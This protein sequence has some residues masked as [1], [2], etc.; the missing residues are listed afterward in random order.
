MDSESDYE[1]GLPPTKP[2]TPKETFSMK[3]LSLRQDEFQ[4]QHELERLYRLTFESSILLN[5]I[6][7]YQKQWCCTLDLF[8]RAREALDK[9]MDALIKCFQEQRAAERDWL[10]FWGMNND[11]GSPTYSPAGWI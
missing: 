8:E 10:A 9:T 2:S 1:R 4:K 6:L 11:A 5:H 3:S 7:K